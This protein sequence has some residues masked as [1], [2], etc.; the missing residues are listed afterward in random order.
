MT[1]PARIAALILA[2]GLLPGLEPGQADRA[3]GHADVPARVLT[4]AGERSGSPAA[5]PTVTLA[6][7]AW[8][9]GTWRGNL[10]DA[11]AEIHYMSPE[12][13]VLPSIFRLREGEEVLIIELL[14]L[15]EDEDGLVMHIRHFTEDLTPLEEEHPLTIRM[16]EGT[17]DRLLFENVRDENPRVSEM[18]RTGP[19]A[20]TSRSELLRPDGSVDTIE[21]AYTR[22]R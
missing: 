9:E 21:V 17:P 18:V 12:A 10:G 1:G 20:F 8:L 22:V 2:A 5:D 14:T 13:G 7:L 6:D 4:A 3:G 16:V 11:V 19:D 15:I